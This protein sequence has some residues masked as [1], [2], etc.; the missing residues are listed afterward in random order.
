TMTALENV[1][2]PLEFAGGAAPFERAQNVL[3]TVGLGHRL[4]HFPAQLSGG[5]QQRVAL[6]R[7][8]AN[9]PRIL[10]A[11]EPT[12][13]LD[14][15]SGT[16]VVDQL[17]DLHRQQG[18]TLVLITHDRELAGRCERVVEIRDGAISGEHA[19]GLAA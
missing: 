19:A 14:A 15:A 9:T 5:E 16:V 13:N 3:E 1:A 17:F 4:Q 10:L 7:A 2:L 11:D 6:A 18:T 8:M 12:G